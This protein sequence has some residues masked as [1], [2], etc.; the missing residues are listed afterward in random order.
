MQAT[1]IVLL[2]NNKDGTHTIK[3][4]SVREKYN[5]TKP[6][7]QKCCNKTKV[8][9]WLVQLFL[10]YFCIVMVVLYKNIE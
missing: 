4:D 7:K 3:P 10:F 1:P 5:N 6:W 9:N 8:A 2:Q